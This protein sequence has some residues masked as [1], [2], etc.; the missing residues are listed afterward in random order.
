[1]LR[2]LGGYVSDECDAPRGNPD[3]DHQFPIFGLD[4]A[5]KST[6]L[7][8]LF[9]SQHI[10]TF[11]DH[12]F[13]RETVSVPNYYYHHQGEGRK[14]EGRDY[15]K[16]LKFRLWDIAGQVG[17]IPLWHVYVEEIQAKAV[18]FVVDSTDWQRLL[19]TK[20]ALWQLFGHYDDTE[21]GRELVLLVF[22]NKQD[23]GGA[24]TVNEV[25][26]GL[27]L[28]GLAARA[29]GG[30]GGRRWHIRGTDATTGEGLV[31]GLLWLDVQ[32][33]GRRPQP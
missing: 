5:G 3:Y 12:S 10:L 17:I 13:R 11:P 24:M 8:H 1:M 16:E 4:A 26:C 7:Y 28:E 23:Q 2:R 33:R 19:Y 22:A 32:L 29:L 18:I 31:E 21:A 30:Q 15:R 27:D 9:Y 20:D 14:G 25:M 6:L